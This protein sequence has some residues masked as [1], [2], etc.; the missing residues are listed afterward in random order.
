[1][2]APLFIYDGGMRRARHA[3]HHHYF[4]RRVGRRPLGMRGYRHK[5]AADYRSDASARLRRRTDPRLLLVCPTKRPPDASGHSSVRIYA[6]EEYIWTRFASLRIARTLYVGLLGPVPNVF[7]IHTDANS[8][9]T[10][11]PSHR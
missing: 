2:H 11:F 5:H 8:R 9:S 10:V 7:F 3:W 1:M 4:V 6:S